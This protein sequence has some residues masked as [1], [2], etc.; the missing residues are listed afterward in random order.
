MWSD[1]SVD[2][3]SPLMV[4]RFVRASVL[5]PFW[6]GWD[7]AGGWSV[8]FAWVGWLVGVGLSTVLRAWVPAWFW[9]WE[10]D[11]SFL[12]GGAGEEQGGAGV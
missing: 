6:R 9:C 10:M 7:A 12:C 2:T 3:L 4:G 5:G 8:V 1:L 11:A